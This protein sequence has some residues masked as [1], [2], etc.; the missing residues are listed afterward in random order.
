[1]K[2]VY[3]FSGNFVSLADACLYSE[4]QWEED[5]PAVGMQEYTNWEEYYP[6]PSLLD[7]LKLKH[8]NSDFVE[9]VGGDEC[10]AYVYRVLASTE[11]CERFNHAIHAEDNVFVLIYA[12]AL[13]GKSAQMMDTSQL[14]YLGEYQCR[15]LH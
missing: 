9:T 15:Y 2:R 14:H 1:M 5:Q 7:E 8:L 4:H 3:I 6:S 13:N 12:E 10:L 11:E